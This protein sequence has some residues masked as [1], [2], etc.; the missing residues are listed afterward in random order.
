[1]MKSEIE[2]T[3]LTYQYNDDSFDVFFCGGQKHPTEFFST[4]VHSYM[5]AGRL[6]FY[7]KLLFKWKPKPT[8]YYR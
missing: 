1:M 5:F 7:Q 8:I 6:A 3:K 4:F 2:Q